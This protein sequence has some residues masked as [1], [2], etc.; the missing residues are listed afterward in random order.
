MSYYSYTILECT[1]S[2]LISSASTF[3]KESH[4]EL[5]K[6]QHGKSHFSTWK[7]T[8]VVEIIELS[9]SHP[10]E[11]FIAECHWDTEYYDRIRYFFEFKNGKCRELGIKPGYA[12]FF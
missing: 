9:K 2:E 6:I 8:M 10:K 5:L 4:S 7:N 12:F 1:N 3:V 11:T